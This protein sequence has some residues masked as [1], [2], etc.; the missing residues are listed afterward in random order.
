MTEIVH[1]GSLIVDDVEDGSVMRRGGPCTY[2]KYGMDYSV[3]AGNFM[4]F[5]PLIKI[6]EFVK[7]EKI[8]EKL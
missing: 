5:A 1:N 7:N 2:I 4:Y 6:K 8:I 3:N